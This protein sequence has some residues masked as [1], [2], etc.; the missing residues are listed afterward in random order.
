MQ[1]T[2]IK[3]PPRAEL[4]RELSDGILINA[5][6][7]LRQFENSPL[8]FVMCKKIEDFRAMNDMRGVKP[9]LMDDKSY[10]VAYGVYFSCDYFYEIMNMIIQEGSSARHKQETK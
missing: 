6:D 7:D 5:L 8:W 9:K 3:R 1:N 10:G 4:D 2:K